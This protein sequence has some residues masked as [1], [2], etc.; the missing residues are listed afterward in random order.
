MPKNVYDNLRVFRPDSFSR[1]QQVVDL[2]YG[3]ACL[4]E[5]IF[6]FLGH[7]AETHP[8]VVEILDLCH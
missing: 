1:F 7:V 4:G 8:C 6:S 2:R 3:L 5:L